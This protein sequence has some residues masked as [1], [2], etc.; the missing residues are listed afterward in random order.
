MTETT[1][2][3]INIF[4]TND[5]DEELEQVYCR[6][7]WAIQIGITIIVMAVSI[8]GVVSSPEPYGVRD[9]CIAIASSLLG[10]HL[11]RPKIK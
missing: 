6:M 4:H 11:P 5:V 9:V 10:L 2:T 7:R 1:D 8:Y 3:V